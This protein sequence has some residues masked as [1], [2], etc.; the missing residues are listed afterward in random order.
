MNQQKKIALVTGASRGIGKEIA[1][2]LSQNGYLVIC[3]GRN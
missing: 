2:T 1:V 3:C